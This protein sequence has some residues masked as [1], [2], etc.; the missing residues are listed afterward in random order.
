MIIQLSP[1]LHKTITYV[2]PEDLFLRKGSW[3]RFSQAWPDS[4]AAWARGKTFVVSQEPLIVPYQASRILPGNDYTDIDLSNATAGLKLY[5]ESEGRVFQIGVGFK[6]GQYIVHTY[7]PTPRYVY[8]LEDSSMFPDVT[9]ATLK[10]LGAKVPE[11]SPFDAPLWQLFAIKDMVAF[12]LRLYV[13]D[14]IDFEKVTVGFWINKCMLSEIPKPVDPK[15]IKT[16]TEEERRKWRDWE[17]IQERA[18]LLRFI[19]EMLAK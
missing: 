12:I 15:T 9:S 10:Y 1:T 16:P 7:V 19:D 8:S 4:P 18:L 2:K 6:P 17:E 11:E 13:L 14:G 5:P 3:V